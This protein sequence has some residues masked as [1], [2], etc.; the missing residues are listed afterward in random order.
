M[1]RN[2]KPPVGGGLTVG[3]GP[4]IFPPRSDGVDRVMPCASPV[5]HHVSSAVLVGATTR[6]TSL[7]LDRGGGPQDARRDV[8][9]REPHQGNL[10]KVADSRVAPSVIDLH[11]QALGVTPSGARAESTISHPKNR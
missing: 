9:K 10:A 8:G 2:D 3:D 4:T 6:R 7:D 11:D 5:K 1:A